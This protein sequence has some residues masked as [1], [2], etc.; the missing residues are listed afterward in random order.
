MFVMFVTNGT[1]CICLFIEICYILLD[2][3][4]FQFTQK[5][6]SLHVESNF[7]RAI[8]IFFFYSLIY[9]GGIPISIRYRYRSEFA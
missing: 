9:N 8:T 5:Q 4:Y 7:Y 6:Y 3:V 2:A 1:A